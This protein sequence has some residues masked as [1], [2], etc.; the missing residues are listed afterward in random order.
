MNIFVL[1]LLFSENAQFHCDAHVVKMPLES[2]QMLCSA[3][4][5]LASENKARSPNAS[6][7]TTINVYTPPYKLAHKNHPCSKWV[8]E[9]LENYVW[10]C[11]LA[12]A[13]CIEY[14][15][16]YGRVHACEKVVDELARNHPSTIESKGLTPF[17]QAMPDAYKC[18]SN[19]NNDN[20]G[21]EEEESNAAVRAYREYY[22]FEKRR[23]FKWCGN[24]KHGSRAKPSWIVRRDTQ[25]DSWL[26][27]A[28]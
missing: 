6:T 24:K 5:V 18:N 14:T 7:P 27:E 9:S 10:L 19:S 28:M 8:R 20:E 21:K 4:H 13:L 11:K 1:S 16:R 3:H 17:A 2:C 23:L 26:E 15:H 12:K 25:I 22:Y